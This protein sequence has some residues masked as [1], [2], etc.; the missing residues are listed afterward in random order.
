MT[1]FN[2]R[3]KGFEGKFSQDQELLFKVKA[4]RNRLLG[5]WA[6]E[7][8]GLSGTAAEAF[9]KDVVEAELEKPDE[10]VIGKIAREFAAKGVKIGEPQVLDEMKRVAK[11]ASKQITGE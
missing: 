8:L 2:D 6:A 3:E 5:L 10:H 1:C 9:A 4:R 11:T 7:K